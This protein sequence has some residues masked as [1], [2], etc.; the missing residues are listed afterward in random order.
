VRGLD[1]LAVG[2]RGVELGCVVDRVAVIDAVG[3]ADS[4]WRD[5]SN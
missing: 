3:H 1:R 5:L 4:E 2:D